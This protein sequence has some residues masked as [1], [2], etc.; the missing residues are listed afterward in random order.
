MASNLAYIEQA[1]FRPGPRPLRVEGVPP[2]GQEVKELG[3]LDEAQT[4][5][6]LQDGA[7]PLDAVV[8]EV[9]REQGQPHV[10]QHAVKLGLSRLARPEV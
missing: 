8:Q 6:R 1:G 4:L 5:L 7:L 9:G 3:L 10:R 2:V